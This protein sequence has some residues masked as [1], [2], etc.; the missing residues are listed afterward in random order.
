MATKF[1][2]FITNTG[3]QSI[4]TITKDHEDHKIS[5]CLLF[6]SSGIME[7]IVFGLLH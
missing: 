7:R 2:I 4:A 5:S 1:V 6:L 3:M